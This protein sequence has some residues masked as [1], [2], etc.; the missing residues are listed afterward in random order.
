MALSGTPRERLY[1][2]IERGGSSNGSTQAAPRP[3]ESQRDPRVAWSLSRVIAAAPEQ[4][5]KV[6]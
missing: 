2:L 4:L 6:K 1:R 3:S 5:G